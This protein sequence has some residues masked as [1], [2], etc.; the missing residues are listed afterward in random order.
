MENRDDNN[1]IDIR[2]RG[3]CFVGVQTVRGLAI[4][5]KGWG[6][7]KLSKSKYILLCSTRYEFPHMI[8]HIMEVFGSLGLDPLINLSTTPP[9]LKMASCWPCILMGKMG[10]GGRINVKT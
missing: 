8:H 3:L 6:R 9:S 4:G 5:M 7:R 10:G 2:N 1:N